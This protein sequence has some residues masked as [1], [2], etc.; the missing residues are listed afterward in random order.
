MMFIDN[1]DLI[2]DLV[3]VTVSDEY[4]DGLCICGEELE[5]CPEAYVHMTSGC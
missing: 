3:E 1:Q 2:Q 4:E 5:S